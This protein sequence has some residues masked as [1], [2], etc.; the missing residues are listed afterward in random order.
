MF[1]PTSVKKQ[2]QQHKAKLK[3]FLLS[4]QTLKVYVFPLIKDCTFEFNCCFLAL[5]IISSGR[6]A[7]AILRFRIKQ[8]E[9]L[10]FLRMSRSLQNCNQV[11]DNCCILHLHSRF[12]QSHHCPPSCLITHLFPSSPCLFFFFFFYS[13][14]ADERSRWFVLWL[15]SAPLS[16][17]SDHLHLLLSNATRL[18]CVHTG[19]QHMPETGSVQNMPLLKFQLKQISK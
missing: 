12:H 5:N 16:P 8:I 2:Q 10:K 17:L 18:S 1:F 19:L 14:A 7:T 4:L 9:S 3:V 6:R 11:Y 15:V 13:E